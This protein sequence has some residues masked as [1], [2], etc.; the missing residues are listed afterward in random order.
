[1][2][3][4]VAS[5]GDVETIHANYAKLHPDLVVPG[6][7]RQYGNTKVLEVYAYYEGEV[8]RTPADKGTVL[9]FVEIPDG[10]EVYVLPGVE[11]VAAT[12]DNSSVPLYSDHWVSNVHS[13][14]GFLDT[15]NDTLGFTPKVDFNAGVVAAGEAQ[16]ESTVIGNS[17]AGVTPH[18]EPLKTFPGTEMVFVFTR[19]SRTAP[20]SIWL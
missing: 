2:L 5:K 8:R 17:P 9:R 14:V 18:K 19:G 11:K 7:P 15:L 1:M 3:G 12:F 20:G 13:R 6:T 10:D 16:I 4:F